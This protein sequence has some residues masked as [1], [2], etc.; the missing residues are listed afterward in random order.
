[1]I[2]VVIARCAIS[3]SA[4]DFTRFRVEM[5]VQDDFSEALYWSRQPA[6]YITR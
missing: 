4:C 3:M 5:Q 6:S 2:Y 1:M